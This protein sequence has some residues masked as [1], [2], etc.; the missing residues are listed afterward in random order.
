MK[1]KTKSFIPILKNRRYSIKKK[2]K[3]KTGFTLIEML[4]SML[5]LVLLILGMDMGMSAA[6][7]V[8]SESVFES[9]S[10]SLS[11]IL[12]TA[13]GDVLRYSEDIKI[14]PGT[15]ED[16]DGNI[17]PKEDVGFVF[18]NYEYGVRNA[19]FYTEILDDGT[20]RGTLQM[21]NL[22]K[23]NVQELVNTGAYPHLEITNFVITYVPPTVSGTAEGGYFNVEYDILDTQKDSRRRHTET[24]VRLMNR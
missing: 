16:S 14:N 19:Y 11:G 24:V 1:A 22:R 5:I 9:N 8:Y 13:I 18:T 15:F 12:N 10:G 17:L 3:G 23:S 21:K 20:S 6:S 4:A 7:R 2:L